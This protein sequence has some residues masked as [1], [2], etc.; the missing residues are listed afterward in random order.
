MRTR[1]PVI[2]LAAM[3]FAFTATSV[4]SAASF[5]SPSDAR[6]LCGGKKKDKD[7]KG[8]KG[9]SIASN[10]DAP[11]C[12]GKKKDKDGKGDKGDS[13]AAATAHQPGA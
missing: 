1:H 5:S 13:I 4:A 6:P 2:G 3:L 11:S 12:G 10:A 8:D 7:G 9:D